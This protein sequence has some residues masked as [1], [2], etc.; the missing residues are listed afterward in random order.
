MEDVDEFL[1]PYL[2]D[3]E[4]KS[5]LDV[6][7]TLRNGIRPPV[8]RFGKL[9]TAKLGPIDEH[10]VASIFWRMLESM[11]IFRGWLLPCDFS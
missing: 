6:G 2:W 5:A 4:Q 1:D 3:E 9:S 8:E 7:L 10:F 11:P